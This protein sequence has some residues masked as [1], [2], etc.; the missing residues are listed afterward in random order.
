MAGQVNLPVGNYEDVTQILFTMEGESSDEPI[1]ISELS[2]V[3]CIG[4][5]E[6]L[7]VNVINEYYILKG[8]Q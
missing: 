7:P 8:E 3:G 6:L 4:Q 2:I 5:G 1:E